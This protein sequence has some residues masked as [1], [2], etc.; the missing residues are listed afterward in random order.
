MKAL[1]RGGKSAANVMAMRF[2]G[3][4][5]QHHAHRREGA[6]RM[7]GR[8][9]PVVVSPQR[10]LKCEQLRCLRPDVDVADAD[11]ELCRRAA[12]T[13]ATWAAWYDE[14]YTCAAL[15]APLPWEPGYVPSHIA[16]V[17][18]MHNNVISATAPNL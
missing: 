10:G 7:S 1:D 15:G 4:Q 16:R 12:S 17:A 2:G 18:M 13:I 5:A 8:V 6:E 11:A 9:N 3:Q 14:A